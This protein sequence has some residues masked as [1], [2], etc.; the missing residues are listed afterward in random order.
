MERGDRNKIARCPHPLGRA[1]TPVL[2]GESSGPLWIVTPKFVPASSD[3]FYQTPQSDRFFS[4]I[5]PFQICQHLQFRIILNGPPP[6]LNRSNDWK[7][8]LPVPTAL[9]KSTSKIS[10]FFFSKFLEPLLTS[11]ES[12][13]SSLISGKH[14]RFRS[15]FP[16]RKP[17]SLAVLESIHLMVSRTPFKVI[18]T[19]K[20]QFLEPNL[21]GFGRSIYDRRPWIKSG[22]KNLEKKKLEIFEVDFCNAVGT[23]NSSFQSLD[24]F[25][26]GGGPFK[27]ILNC[28]CW[29]IWKGEIWLKN[30]SDWG[31]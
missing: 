17:V 7:E 22:S 2:G 19:S 30:L 29:H 18:H 8:L 12:S 1:Q 9:Q 31:V 6:S 16:G 25:N 10:T 15:C 27:I 13:E 4:Q 28:R 26:D 23:G 24:L 11:S 20:T 21:V 14:P 3:F 5:S